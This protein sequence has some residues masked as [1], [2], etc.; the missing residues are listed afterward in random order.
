MRPLSLNLLTLGEAVLLAALWKAHVGRH[1][2]LLPTATWVSLGVDGLS[3]P[4]QVVG[5]C[6][7]SQQLGCKLM[8]DLSQDPSAS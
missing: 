2:S 6:R 7:T 8:R 5:D 4:I 1:R 3:S